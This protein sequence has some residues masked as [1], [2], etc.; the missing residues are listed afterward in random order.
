MVARAGL[1]RIHILPVMLELNWSMNSKKL[2]RVVLIAF[3]TM[4]GM[5]LAQADVPAFFVND[6]PV[7]ES[8]LTRARRGDQLSTLD[9]KGV[10]GLDVQLMFL[11]QMV[12]IKTAQQDSAN[13]LVTP[14]EVDESIAQ[15][16][17]QNN[18][19]DDELYL[20]VIQAQ[21]FTDESFHASQKE[22][23]QIQKRVEEI[24]TS[25]K[26]SDAEL[27]LYYELHSD[28]YTEPGKPNAPFEGLS[29][30]FRE[31]LQADANKIK[32]NEVIEAWVED[33][34]TNADVRFPENSKLELFNPAIASVD[35]FEIR[36]ATLLREVYSNPQVAS[37]LQS[38]TIG[39]ET[40][41][42]E[43]SSKFKPQALENLINRGI[44]RQYASRSLQAFFGNHSELFE[45]IGLERV[46]NVKVSEAQI[47]A[48][49]LQNIN[50]YRTEASVD[51]VVAIFPSR[52]NADAFRKQILK[53]KGKDFSKLASKNRGTSSELGQ[54]TTD[55]LRLDLQRSLLDAKKLTRV[56][57]QYISSVIAY[58]GKFEV[59]LVQSLQPV[60]LKPF[61]SVRAGVEVRTRVQA[62]NKAATAW[63]AA[64]RKNHVI[65]NNL[66]AVQAELEARAK[67]MGP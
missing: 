33:I 26:P 38:S 21:G 10:I 13:I 11:N 59:Y 8:E 7:S 46:G 15:I 48:F 3:V 35:G 18:L 54:L 1:D 20:A 56:G 19:T 23:L 65:V 34:T 61:P 55:Q 17:S 25:A 52:K 41:E 36:L 4:L 12:L 32:Q 2:A 44:A 27:K 22:R 14:A 63:W 50:D 28:Q 31:K 40:K 51:L 24:T 67:R 62:R 57:D 66:P 58:D 43:F 47:K 5:A 60:D 30:G 16:R 49:Y 64:E 45:Q 42:F 39:P 29:L 37:F 9:L 53:V 6:Q